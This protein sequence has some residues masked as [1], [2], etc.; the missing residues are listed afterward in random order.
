MRTFRKAA[1]ACLISTIAIINARSQN[2]NLSINE[3]GNPPDG[4]AI[5]DVTSASKGMLIPR[6]ALTQTTSQS[7]ITSPAT[8]LLVWNTATVN[9]V[10]P[11]YY[12]WG[13]TKWEKMLVIGGGLVGPTGANGATGS[14]GVAGINGAVGATGAQGIQGIQ[15]VTGADGATGTQGLPGVTGADGATGA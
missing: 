13:G 6:V 3:T 4:S 2:Q 1:I 5:L 12:Y 8:S 14:Q 11:G 15:G 7:P 10:T 9:D